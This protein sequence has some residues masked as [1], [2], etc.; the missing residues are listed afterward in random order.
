M[1]DLNEVVRLFMVESSKTKAVAIIFGASLSGKNAIKIV[2][3][4]FEVIA[5]IDNAPA[6]QG[7][8]ISN[9]PVYGAAKISQLLFDKILIASE[10]AEK[11]H[12]Q[13][14]N[15]YSIDPDNIIELP[16]RVT[17]SIQFGHDEKFRQLSMQILLLICTRLNKA[18]VPYYIDAGTLL[19]IYRDGALIPWD[20]DLDIAV[21]SHSLEHVKTVITACLAELQTLT[22]EPW[23]LITHFS[24]KQ[25]GA[26]N[27]GDVRGLKIKSK[28]TE[29]LLPMM[30]VFVKYINEDVMDYTLASR[31]FRMPSEHILTLDTMDF[32]G[33]SIN[34]PSQ[35]ALYLQRHYGDW[36]TPKEDWK[37]SEI[38]S[39]TVF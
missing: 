5:F 17:K 21:P 25:F 20:D 12:E 1:F 39:A 28:N 32:H 37:M 11:I 35:P 16:N 34:I 10:F 22:N 7:T 26:V 33:C 18:K 2:S 23:E 24:E 30:D 9:I 8:T 36:Q 31:G 38:K 29:T 27:S 4:S 3:E 15:E 6:R 13:L 19:G 14:I